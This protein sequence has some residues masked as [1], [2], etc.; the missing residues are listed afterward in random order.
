MNSYLET[1]PVEAPDVEN[2]QG[3]SVRVELTQGKQHARLH[4]VTVSL[5]RIKCA[6]S[7]FMQPVQNNCH[8]R[9][10]K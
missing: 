5:F 7:A 10:L 4:H 2:R 3:Q 1:A 9:L 8:F 6:L